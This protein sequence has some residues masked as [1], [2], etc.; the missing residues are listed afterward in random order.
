MRLFRLL[1]RQALVCSRL[2]GLVTGQVIEYGFETTR[3]ARHD[4]ARDTFKRTRALMVPMSHATVHPTISQDWVVAV[5]PNTVN[6]QQQLFNVG[7]WFTKRSAC[8][9]I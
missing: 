5:E 3:G 1:P 2:Q 8:V 6:A 9:Q 4:A 7:K